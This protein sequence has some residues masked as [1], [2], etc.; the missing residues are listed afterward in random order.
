MNTERIFTAL[1]EQYGAAFNTLEKIIDFCPNEIW[2]NS[3]NTPPIYGVVNHILYFVDLYLSKSKEERESY[4][5]KFPDERDDM[6]MIRTLEKSD[7]LEYIKEMRSKAKNLFTSMTLGQLQGKPIFEWHG[8]SLLSSLLYNLRHVML[9]IGAL[10]IRLRHYG[11][12]E[13]FWIGNA[14][15]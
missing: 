7:L 13:K 9:H 12:D 15:L 11:I 10:Q 4:K 14:E 5:P 3:P 2:K 8:S 6:Y 1:E